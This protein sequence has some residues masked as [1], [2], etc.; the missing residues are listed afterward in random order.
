V[1][2][3]VKPQAPGGGGSVIGNVNLIDNMIYYKYRREQHR[4]LNARRHQHWLE[5][6]NGILKKVQFPS[7][8]RIIDR[9]ELSN[10]KITMLT[11]QVK[12][13]I[14]VNFK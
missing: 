10:K 7:I 1:I 11:A 9:E 3:K 6:F 2:D 12:D 5:V 14:A 13:L 4:I 8:L